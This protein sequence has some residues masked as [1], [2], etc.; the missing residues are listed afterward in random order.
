MYKARARRNGYRMFISVYILWKLWP[1]VYADRFCTCPTCTWCWT[2]AHIWFNML[3][4]TYQVLMR[5]ITQKPSMSSTSGRTKDSFHQWP[6]LKKNSW[7][8]V[9]ILYRRYR[10][11]SRVDERGS[12]SIWNNNFEMPIIHTRKLIGLRSTFANFT[13]SWR[14]PS[15]HCSK[16]ENA[17]SQL[18][19]SYILYWFFQL[20]TSVRGLTCCTKSIMSTLTSV[21]SRTPPPPQFLKDPRLSRRKGLF[22][23]R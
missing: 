1:C 2:L 10:I 12:Q 7:T 16:Y 15:I 9:S 3:T 5:R 17:K 8:M 19:S 20:K 18:S 11:I 6:N 14:S 4:F 23:Y 21:Y 22:L 13:D